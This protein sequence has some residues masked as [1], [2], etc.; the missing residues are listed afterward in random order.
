MPQTPPRPKLLEDFISDVLN[1]EDFV[2][3]L[4]K[5][6]RDGSSF[7]ETLQII[8]PMAVVFFEK[9]PDRRETPE[10]NDKL[11]YRKGNAAKALDL[12][13]Q[14]ITMTPH[15]PAALA[16][17]KQTI[18]SVYKGY[19]NQDFLQ[20]ARD[21]IAHEQ[22]FEKK[23]LQLAPLDRKF[24][25]SAEDLF[26][27]QIY[28]AARSGKYVHA[29]GLMLPLVNH[30]F[31]HAIKGEE[32]LG[33]QEGSDVPMRIIRYESALDYNQWNKLNDNT[34]KNLSLALQQHN[35]SESGTPHHKA[36]TNFA[37]NMLA[38][39]VPD[40]IM[41]CYIYTD[42]IMAAKSFQAQHEHLPN[43]VCKRPKKIRKNTFT[44]KT[45]EA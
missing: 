44:R 2:Y 43:E 12:A 41:E 9:Y 17:S 32:V 21:Y 37:K 18:L 31:D 13:A 40:N 38:C 8:Y 35:L 23:P 39:L 11:N 1:E 20:M 27:S 24:G 3:V 14:T 36:L 25:K 19:N 4:I 45:C 26:V 10:K 6:I 28:K 30:I 16:W 5:N 29:L 7:I 22:G 15:E 42:L 33:H 34:K